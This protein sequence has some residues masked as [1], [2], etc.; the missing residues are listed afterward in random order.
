MGGILI[1]FKSKHRWKKTFLIL[2]FI[3][4]PF[5]LWANYEGGKP[6]DV[7]R[8]VERAGSSVNFHTTRISLAK[9]KA[10]YSAETYARRACRDYGG[11]PTTMAWR[12]FYSCRRLGELNYICNAM[13]AVNCAL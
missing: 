5:F 2:L 3:N 10:V 8:V 1:S 7:D 6:R 4:S 12:K 11:I 13:A 9:R